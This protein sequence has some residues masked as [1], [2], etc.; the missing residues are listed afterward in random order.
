MTVEVRI[1]RSFSCNNS[2]DFKLVARF[3]DVASAAAAAEEL[4]AFLSAH[5]EQVD[6][7]WDDEPDE[8]G[9]EG[10]ERPSKACHDLAAKHG[11]SWDEFL[12]WGDDGLSGD[13]PSVEVADK[14]LVLYH[15]YCGGFGDDLPKYFQALGAGAEE[16]DGAACISFRFALGSDAARGVADELAAYFARV[17]DP[18]APRYLYEWPP[19]PWG[20]SRMTGRADQV[21]YY[22]DGKSVGVHLPIDISDLPALRTYLEERG[23]GELT[24]SLEEWANRDLF[25]TVAKGKCPECAVAGLTLMAA[26]EHGTDEDQ[27]ACPRC[28]GMFGLASIAVD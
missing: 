3:K 16:E 7:S 24:I 27:L 13:L 15:S 28:G 18:E 23:I 11:F 2:G 22:D 1:W 25:R 9:R 21:A 4:R 19:A 12:M 10:W 8:S 20:A 26:A 6:A 14:T 5:A 17:D